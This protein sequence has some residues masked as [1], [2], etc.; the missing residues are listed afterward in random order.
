MTPLF[1]FI[2]QK[3][4]SILYKQV[5]RQYKE[6]EILNYVKQCVPEKVIKEL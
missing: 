1:L 5:T 3:M 2:L 4:L 6:D